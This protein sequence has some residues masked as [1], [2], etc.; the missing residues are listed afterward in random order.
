MSFSQSYSKITTEGST[1]MIKTNY[2]THTS[3]C[4][5][6]V[7]SDE[8][9]VKAAI[10]A[11]ITTLGF[12]DHIP[13]PID[14]RWRMDLNELEDYIQSIHHLKEKYKDQITIYTGL[15]LEGYP[16]Q[17]EHLIKMR[18]LVDYCILGQHTLELDEH[19]SKNLDTDAY[20]DLYVDRIEWG[21][22]NHLCDYIC[23]PDLCMWDY[24]RM[25][26][27]TIEIATR[28]A[29]L[30]IQYDVPVELNCGAGVH[31]GLIDFEDGPR[32]RYPIRQFFEVF[33]EYNC[34]V[35]IGLDIHD[36][37]DFLTDLYLNRA[38]EVVKGLDLNIIE[39]YDIIASANKCKQLL[40]K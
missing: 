7:G 2:H 23:H 1:P 25:D 14:G 3:R 24:P 39:E 22:Q 8:E 30:S 16:S 29:K 10:K 31:L 36:P 33:K 9:Y 35:V 4:K 26:E 28:I 32:Y 19:T 12:S 27:K 11:G 34:K 37:K 15:E 40:D 18:K 20:L 21:L 17:K 38:L 5:H 13:Y 6:A